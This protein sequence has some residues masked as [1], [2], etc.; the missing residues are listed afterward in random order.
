MN[1]SAGTL[2]W[3]DACVQVLSLGCLLQDWLQVWFGFLPSRHLLVLSQ[4]QEREA[5]PGT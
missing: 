3:L 2:G 1:S 4:E 5:S